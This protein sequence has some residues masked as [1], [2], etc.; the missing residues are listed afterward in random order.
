MLTSNTCLVAALHKGYLYLAADRRM[1]W[2]MSQ[3]QTTVRPKCVKRNDLL[4]AGTGVCFIIDEIMYHMDIPKQDN[5]DVYEYMRN[6][7]MPKV[8]DRLKLMG[9][10]EKETNRLV[11]TRKKD[12]GL[13]T[14]ILI[15]IGTN[16]FELDINHD[17]IS[18]DEVN[19]PFAHGCGGKLAWGALLALNTIKSLTIEK[20]LK[21]AVQI[22]AKV[23]PGCDDNVDIIHN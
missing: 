6:K 22:A 11:E 2:N 19:L 17:A 9:I 12:D 23:S 5:L 14:A 15:G 16:L 1:S 8:L 7:F 20:K 13:H 21:L 3:A 10:L 4:F 18:L